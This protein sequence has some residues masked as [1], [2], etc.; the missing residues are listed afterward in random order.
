M[1]ESVRLAL[2]H[3][4]GQRLA[5]SAAPVQQVAEQFARGAVPG[6][7]EATGWLVKAAREV[8]A[9]PPTLRPTYWNAP[10]G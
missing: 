7:T 3:Q 10:S 6:D 1:P 9:A 8:A 2:H 4:A 5:G